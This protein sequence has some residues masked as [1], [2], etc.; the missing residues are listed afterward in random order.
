MYIFVSIIYIFSE[1]WS[2][3]R[4]AHIYEYISNDP[5]KLLLQVEEGGKNFSVGQRQLLSLSRAI[6]RHSKVILMDEV[7]ASIDYVTDKLIQTTIRT[8]EVLKSSTIITVG[9][10]VSSCVAIFVNIQFDNL[11]HVYSSS[12]EDDS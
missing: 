9:K 7:T 11:C 8:S 1:I 3:L 4:D 2:A 6:L 12:I 10:L 5:S